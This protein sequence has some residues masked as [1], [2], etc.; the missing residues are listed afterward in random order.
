[1]TALNPRTVSISLAAVVVAFVSGMAAVA[2]HAAPQVVHL[3]KA[4]ADISTTQTTSTAPGSTATAQPAPATSTSTTSPTSLISTN[5]PM[6]TSPR[7]TTTAPTGAPITTSTTPAMTAVSAQ[8]TGWS[9]PVQASPTQS[10]QLNLPQG[11]LVRYVYCMWTYSGGSTR[12]VVT[13]TGYTYPMSINQQNNVGAFP[14]DLMFSDNVPCDVADA[15][16]A[17]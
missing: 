17:N 13:K 8:L 14:M 2:Y 7:T 10:K 5:S 1:M 9:D 4:T 15:P 11:T 16:L 6:P 3:Y 12:Q